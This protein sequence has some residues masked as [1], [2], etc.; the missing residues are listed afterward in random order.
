MN[1]I[2]GID[3]DGVLTDLSKFYIE[4]GKKFF[5]KDPVNLNGYSI[6]EIFDCSDKDEF[7]YGL[8]NFIKY[9]KKCEPRVGCREIIEQLNLDG[10][11]LHE[12]TARK[13]VTMNN[14]IGR[15][16]RNLLEKWYKRHNMKF[17]TIQY[18]SETDS[19]TDKLIGCSKLKVDVMI[20]DKPDVALKLAKNGIKV[21]LF[22]APYNQN[23]IHENIERVYNWNEVY[24]KITTL[25]KSLDKKSSEMF[26]KKPKEEIIKMS[27]PEKVKYFKLYHSMLKSSDFDKE[28]NEKNKRRFKLIRTLGY[29]PVKVIF[30]PIVIGKEN[31]PYQ[32][33]I[34]YASNHLNNY[35]QF[36]ISYAL[37]SKALD[38]IAASTIEHTPRGRLFK[39]INV[40]F[41]D[42]E[43]SESKKRVEHETEISVVNGNDL[44]IFPEGTRKNK[45][46][47]G[48]KK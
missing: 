25:A 4:D 31:I 38:G 43:S 33:G 15:Y 16:S 6:K 11:E 41:V 36:V 30:N 20:E 3:T 14:P 12:I 48:R 5:K 29:L 17:K 39:K 32:N 34:I 40:R 2:I 47:E 7:R 9:C 22:D 35:D 27:Q 24:D 28:T 13:F 1:L 45:D 37:G 8:F 19:P 10:H 46:E 44:L 21:I 26:E 42:R 23:L 18:C